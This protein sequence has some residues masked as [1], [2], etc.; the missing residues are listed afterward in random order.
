MEGGRGVF[1]L[2]MIL[3]TPPKKLCCRI[4]Y[5]C[6]FI[7][8]EDIMGFM[9]WRWRRE[10]SLCEEMLNGVE[11]DGKPTTALLCA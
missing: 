10:G 5:D 1:R 4:L 2:N 11:A 8:W 6:A 3:A 9:F 7:F